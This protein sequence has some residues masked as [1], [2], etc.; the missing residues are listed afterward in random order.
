VLHQGR[1]MQYGSPREVYE[2]PVH[3][4]VAS[5]VGRPGMDLLRCEVAREETDLIVRLLGTEVETTWRVPLEELDFPVLLPGDS[6]QVDLGVRSANILTAPDSFELGSACY[7]APAII[8]RLEYQGGS[9]LLAT[10]SLGAQY[11]HALITSGPDATEGQQLNVYFDLGLASWFD[12]ETGLRWE[13]IAEPA[14]TG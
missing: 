1:L 4:F 7:G 13:P 12:V 8:R 14:A 5:F 2:R 9:T 3:R 6:R 10:L 11:V